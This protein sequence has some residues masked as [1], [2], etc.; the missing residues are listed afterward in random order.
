MNQTQRERLKF[1]FQSRPFQWIPLPDILH[2]GLA[3]YGTRIL[4]LRRTGMVIENKI[5]VVNGVRHSWFRNVPEK[6]KQL[7]FI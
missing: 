5:E 3:Q 7:I 1:L 4:E 6:D 2:L